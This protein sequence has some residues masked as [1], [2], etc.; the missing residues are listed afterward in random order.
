MNNFFSK[1][2]DEEISQLPPPPAEPVASDDV[3]ENGTMEE[4]KIVENGKV[5][6]KKWHMSNGIM[7]FCKN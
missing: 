4:E 3:K 7:S 6:V 1:S 5:S 2:A